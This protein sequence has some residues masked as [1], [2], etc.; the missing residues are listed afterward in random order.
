M[1]R[2]DG[3]AR[4]KLRGTLEGEHADVVPDICWQDESLREGRLSRHEYSVAAP[5][6]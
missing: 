4:G 5:A 1:H 2:S 3:G 6:F